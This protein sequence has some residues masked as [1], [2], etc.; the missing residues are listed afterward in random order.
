MINQCSS[1]VHEHNGCFTEGDAYGF[2]VVLLE[3]VTGQKPLEASNVEDGFKGKL[4][5][6]VNQL[7]SSG[8]IKDAISRELC[9]KGYDEEI[10]KLLKIA[11]NCVVSWPKD[12]SCSEQEDVFP[13]FFG[14]QENDS[15]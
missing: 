14:K 11:C 2:G 8:R 3:L 1:G 12:H 13:L 10:L 6:W 9:G 5:D 4:V 7:S 15:M